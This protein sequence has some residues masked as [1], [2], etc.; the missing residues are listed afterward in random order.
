M[1]VGIISVFGSVIFFSAR[2]I[3]LTLDRLLQRD[4]HARDKYCGGLEAAASEA[5]LSN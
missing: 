4:I 2:S 1:A 3:A 5:E